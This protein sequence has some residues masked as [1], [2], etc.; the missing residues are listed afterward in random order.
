M[1]CHGKPGARSVALRRVIAC[2]TAWTFA[3]VPS[4]ASAG[5]PPPASTARGVV[6]P[7]LTGDESGVL[8]F[9]TCK[10]QPRGAKFTI[11]LPKEAELEDL[12]N[13]MMTI[14]CQKFIWDPKV[15]SG[16]V[17]ILSPE[18]ITVSE[19]Y[20][21]FYAALQQMGLTVEPSGDYFKI[22]E[23]QNSESKNLPVYGP[24]GRAPNNDRYVTQL[25]RTESGNTGEIVE[26]LNKLKSKQGNVQVAGDLMILTDTGA[27]VRRLMKIVEQLDDPAITRDKIFFYQLRYANPE[28]VA[29]IVRDIFAEQDGARPQPR[30]RGRRQAA[31][32]AQ[33]Q[34]GNDPSFSRVI[35]DERTG[36]LIIVA[37][38]ADYGVIRRLIEQLDVPLAGTGS[39]RIHVRR[40]RNADPDEVA[41]VLQQLAS[42]AQA[43]NRNQGGN[44]RARNQQQPPPTQNAEGEVAVLFSGD[45]KVASDPATRSLV[46]LASQSDYF[47][48]KPVIDELDQERKQV[49]IEVYL[50]EVTIDHSLEGGAT[51]HFGTTFDAGGQDG[52]GFVASAPNP[53]FNSV[54]PSSA[55]LS[56][57]V[58][59]VLGPAVPGSG[60]FFGIPGRDIPA[61]GVIIQALQNNN[62]VN[63]I[64]EPHMFAAD[65]QE[66]NIEVG[67]NVPTPGALTFPGGGAGGGLVPVQS[68]QREDV[69]LRVKIT[70]HINDD[71]MVTL[72]V[73]MENRD[74]QSQDPTLGVTTSKRRLKLDKVV[75]RDELPIVLGGLVREQE[76]ETVQQVPGLGSIPLLGWL[77]KRK[78]KQRVKT[79]LLMIL[80]PHII[81]TPDEVRRIH[82]QRAQE[83][84]DFVQQNTAFKT[85]DLD[86]NVNYRNKRGVL[87]TVNVEAK[88]MEQE[89]D[90]YRQMQKELMQET[91]TGEIGMSPRVA[92]ESDAESP[93][94]PVELPPGQRQQLERP[95]PQIQV[96]P[97]EE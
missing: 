44:N 58:G 24:E 93:E 52:F 2:F 14:S 53:N 96:T 82:A 40:L 79:N 77:F 76:Q 33:N 47:S 9:N 78:R 30:R 86:A 7:E 41:K 56:G 4:F 22:V 71:T 18:A 3:F 37:Q 72:D 95:Q 21:A 45:I 27:S 70:P 55:M 57:I 91:I 31:R 43:G 10:K 75:A 50:L 26:V 39:A 29:T 69:T 73:E 36:T 23:T 81:E 11:T 88:R 60:Q 5:P 87:A 34:D 15:R 35:V 20:A 62:D 28:E 32:Q 61:F 46:I 19:A 66:A 54:I 42:G 83:R 38:D 85:R 92:G 84:L 80:V 65:N 25:F 64:A 49:Y 89:E 97:A 12:V 1:S 6:A 74:I 13:W 59:G 48:L 94:A 17:T 68:I 67:S 8:P 90:R 51:G 16:K 63:L